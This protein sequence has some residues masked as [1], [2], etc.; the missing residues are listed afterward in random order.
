M[1][2]TFQF[3]VL[4]AENN[5]V[6]SCHESRLLYADVA[7][8]SKEVLVGIRYDPSYMNAPAIQGISSGRRRTMIRRTLDRMGIEVFD[9]PPLARL[10]G[11]TLADG[12]EIPREYYPSVAEVL[13]HVA[14]YRKD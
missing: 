9:I 11:F 3:F 5:A 1:R 10:L 7:V 2:E 13:A 6:L 4:P 8:A 14:K 12:Q